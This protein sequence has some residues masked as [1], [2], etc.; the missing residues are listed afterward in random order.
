MGIQNSESAEQGRYVV[1]LSGG[2]LVDNR[3]I[4]PPPALNACHKSFIVTLVSSISPLFFSFSLVWAFHGPSALQYSYSVPGKHFKMS[5]A[6]VSWENNDGSCDIL[7][8]TAIPLS[9]RVKLDMTL[10]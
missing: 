6:G 9:S 2:D 7:T 10:I 8:E 1:H 4:K 3:L 5:T